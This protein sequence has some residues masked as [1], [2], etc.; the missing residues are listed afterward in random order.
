MLRPE[1]TLYWF[2]PFFKRTDVLQFHHQCRQSDCVAF[3][4]YDERWNKVSLDDLQ[5]LKQDLEH[6]G[7]QLIMIEG[8]VEKTVPSVARVLKAGKVLF[9]TIDNDEFSSLAR[10]ICRDLELH[11]ISFCDPPSVTGHHFSGS[12]YSAIR[13][14]I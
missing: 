6:R 3:F 9:S 4:C 11:S 14:L 13:H 2:T 1:K 8:K 10:K 7:V 5:F 12:N